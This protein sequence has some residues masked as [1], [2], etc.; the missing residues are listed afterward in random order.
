LQQDDQELMAVRC[1]RQG[2][3]RA[4]SQLFDWHFEAVF[5][6]CLRL[7]Q[8]KQS[9]AEEA[10]QEAFMIAAR[11]IH[12]FQPTSGTFRA[13][14]F[15][16][17]QNRCKKLHASEVR[18]QARENRYTQQQPETTLRDNL[19]VAPVH[20]AL[21]HLPPHYRSVLEAKYMSGQTVKQIA[22]TNQISEHAAESLLRRAK[23]KFTQIYTQLKNSHT[24]P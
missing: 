22:Q 7:T 18:R 10:T 24:K 15:G 17:A 23:E 21:A 9:F 4:W 19:S 3:Q 16:I 6:F 12:R 14:L 11:K 13:W 20:E 1:A 5:S 2:D 8:G